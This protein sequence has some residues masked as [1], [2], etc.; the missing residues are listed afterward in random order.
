MGEG[1]ACDWGVAWAL[2][3]S[4][5]ARSAAA[6]ASSTRRLCRLLRLSLAPQQ[7]PTFR[8]AAGM[9]GCC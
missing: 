4:P 2:P 6:A 7:L 5:A 3:P 8:G 1:V 9:G